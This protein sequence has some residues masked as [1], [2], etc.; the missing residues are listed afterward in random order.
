MNA[1]RKP[2]NIRSP[3]PSTNKF[4]IPVKIE[5]IAENKCPIPA[6][7]LLAILNPFPNT[8]IGFAKIVRFNRFIRACVAFC[9]ALS[10][11]V[12]IPNG[13]LLKFLILS[14]TFRSFNLPAFAAWFAF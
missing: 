2:A 5:L 12:R 10:S 13:F 6:T 3:I 11:P 4:V 14:F 7:I 1:K 8:R 9:F